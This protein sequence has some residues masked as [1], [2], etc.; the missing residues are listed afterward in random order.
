M[1][2]IS[3]ELTPNYHD[4]I[5][6]AYRIWWE[7]ESASWSVFERPENSS[8]GGSF[9]NIDHDCFNEINDLVK[10]GGYQDVGISN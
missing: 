10:K 6:S 1:L 5:E 4:G 9:Q 7:A 2:V 3:S 8:C